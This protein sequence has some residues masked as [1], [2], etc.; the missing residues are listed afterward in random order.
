M[1]RKISF[2]N[3]ALERLKKSD[4][5]LRVEYRD[6]GEPGLYIYV[7]ATGL[8]TFYLY[9]KH[10]GR[11]VRI[12]IARYPD[13]SVSAARKRARELKGQLALGLWSA[14]QG[15]AGK[16]D[17]VTLKAVSQEYL[18]VKRTSLKPSTIRSYE[19][20][21][22]GALRSWLNLPI[23]SVGKDELIR[24]HEQITKQRGR[25]AADFA[26]RVFRLYFEFFID[27]YE[28]V[29]VNPAKTLSRNKLWN[30]GAGNR[31]QSIIS[32]ADLPK[33]VE[34]V[35]DL[36]PVHRDYLLLLLFT[37]LRRGE[38]AK[39]RWVDVN[40]RENLLSVNET[41]NGEKLI[42]PMS[43]PLFQILSERQ[44]FT[45]GDWVFPAVSDS[46]KPLV[47]EHLA[48]KLS[49]SSGIKFMLHDL[50]RTFV[51]LAES[52]DLSQYTIKRLVNHKSGMADVTAGYV[53]PNVDRLRDPV[54][55]IANRIIEIGRIQ[56]FE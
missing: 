53:V 35:M 11:P 55:R 36:P 38:A 29:G 52:L 30:T 21:T 45:S 2:S 10:N 24:K 31:R 43:K 28:Y 25:T 56:Y 51:T 12:K 23:A 48:A 15:A 5:G 26:M 41:K 1:G 54:E 3:E 9:R 42:L 19:S 49:K 50:R 22:N 17:R 13:L 16:R 27:R 47:V 40:L 7:T 6:R 32:N 4:N 20:A 46:N 44:K 8:K 39:L 37:G 14:S 34:A 33:W 18:N